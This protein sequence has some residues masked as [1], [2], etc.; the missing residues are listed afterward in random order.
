MG[1]GMKDYIAGEAVWQYPDAGDGLPP[2]SAK[3][4]LLTI[5]G[6]CVVGAWGVGCLAWAPLPKRDKLKEETIGTQ[7]QQ[8]YRRERDGMQKL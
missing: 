2:T 4:L 8:A 6:V 3:C 1:D 7:A 5:G